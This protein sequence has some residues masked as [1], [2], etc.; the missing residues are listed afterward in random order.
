MDINYTAAL[1]SAIASMVLGF[2][3]YS[4][5]LFAT[6]WMTELELSAEDIKSGPGIGYL[7]TFIAAFIMA[8]VTSILVNQ[9]E[10][11]SPQN[12]LL[13]G[14]M[15]SIGYI[16]TTFASNYIFSQKTLKLYLIDTGYQVLNVILAAVIT[17]ALR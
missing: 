16:A 5:L 11:N 15:I 8:A 9:L 3:W 12:A 4:P 1:L 7:I 2:L 14:L 17:S 13:F 10:V 6:A